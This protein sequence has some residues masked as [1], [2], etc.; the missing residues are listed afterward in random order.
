MNGRGGAGRRN[1]F[2]ALRNERSNTYREPD[3]IRT[4]SARVERVELVMER[5]TRVTL[6]LWIARIGTAFGWFWFVVYALCAVVS[7]VD[8]PNADESIDYAMPFVCIGLAAAHFLI[9]RASK[10]TRELVSDFRYYATLLSGNKSIDALSKKVKEPK[11]QIE[12]KII[13]MCK[14]GYFRGKVDPTDDRL[15]LDSEPC[16]ARCPGCGAT[17]QIYRNGDK[18][19]YCGNPL[20]VGE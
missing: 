19:R 5:R 3:S 18:C 7:I 13:L 2:A 15:V 12:K 6:D 14:R 20:E 16:A 9:I 17:T 8:L 4:D 10:R 1:F 11:E